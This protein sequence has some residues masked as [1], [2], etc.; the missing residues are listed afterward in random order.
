MNKLKTI[1]KVI[2]N[3]IFVLLLVSASFI[4]LTTYDVIPGFNFYVVMSGSMEPEIHT[5]SVVGIRE[6]EEYKE[7]DIVTVQMPY[8]QNETYT[9]RIIEVRE[10]E[11]DNEDTT[12]ITKG[13]ANETAD[14]DP[15]SEEQI[16]G[17]V[18]V[19]IPLIGYLVSFAKKP[20][21]FIIL[22]ILPTVI[23]ATSEINAIK[24][25]GKKIIESKKKDG[26]K[27]KKKRKTK[28]EAKNKQG[29]VTRLGSRI[30]NIFNAIVKKIK[31]PFKKV[32]SKKKKK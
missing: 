8:A 18:F 21:G 32:T 2:Y 26:D 17:E 31:A 7:D 16:L 15:V 4:L 28:K 9:H 22:V 29:F 30:V 11:E 13:D 19:S 23:I 1:T 5:G 24:E 25:E 3:I 20:M 6:E 27:S 10:P 12:F 14:G